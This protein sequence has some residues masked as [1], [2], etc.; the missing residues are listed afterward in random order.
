MRTFLFV[1]LAGCS[2]ANPE[3]TAEQQYV[4]TWS[5]SSGTDNVSCPNGTTSAA[6]KGN[7]SIEK[8]ASG[9]VVIDEEGCNFG[10]AVD[11]TAATTRNQSCS[12]PVPELGQGVTAD[13]TY[14]LI[15]LTTGDG[16]N[17]TDSFNG[18]V[19]YKTS[20]GDLDCIFSGSATLAKV[21]TH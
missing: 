16:A 6:L 11:Q 2:S 10:Y 13:V 1:L 14:D 18:K 7:V 21:Q 9:L 4:G 8:S 17:M 3:A 15:T 12:F 20:A 19:T 5:F